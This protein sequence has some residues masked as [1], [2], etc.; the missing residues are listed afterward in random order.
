MLKDLNLIF[1]KFDA[2][3]FGVALVHFSITLYTDS[4]FFKDIDYLTQGLY[5]FTKIAVLVALI[6]FWQEVP[7]VIKRIKDKDKKTLIFYKYFVIYFLIMLVFLIL[8]WPGIWRGDEFGILSDVQQL[9]FCF[10]QHWLTS[11]FYIFC[12]CLAPFP[13]G[14]VIMQLIII[15]SIVAYIITE[16]SILFPS[17]YAWLLII[18]FFFPPMIDNNLYPIR[19]SLYS[20]IELFL[21]SLFIF[22]FTDKSEITNKDIVTWALL[23]SILA[24]WRS[25]GIWFF[26]GLP[27]LLLILF[28]KRI[29]MKKI[30]SFLL[31]FFTLAA[32]IFYVQKRGSD[33]YK[34]LLTGIVDPLSVIVKSDFKSDNKSHDLMVI[35]RVIKVDLLKKYRGEEAFW[36]EGALGELS[37]E[38]MA[39]LFKVY[40]NLVLNNFDVFIQERWDTYI[41]ATG[42]IVSDFQHPSVFNSKNYSPERFLN[43]PFNDNLRMRVISI[44]ECRKKENYLEENSIINYVYGPMY[45]LYLLIFIGIIGIVRRNRLFFSIPLVII[46]QTILTMFTMVGVQFMYFFPSYLCGYV[47][48]TMLMLAGCYR[49]RVMKD[50]KILTNLKR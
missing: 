20:Y 48:I 26:V 24:N 27:F 46:I 12:S 40:I 42:A 38:N 16:F 11:A 18:P 28:A 36:K 34:Y 17:K 8:T 31:I 14:I 25:E 3:F 35:N 4:I 30:V 33:G 29:K 47:F 21:F 7:K 10:W 9:V 5:I 50:F 43:K 49:L 45:P 15:S 23:G 1:S 2:R 37:K 32:S 6:L 44:L 13:V 22:K 19:T 41:Q 39:D